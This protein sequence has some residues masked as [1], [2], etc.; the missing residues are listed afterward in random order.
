[1]DATTMTDDDTEEARDLHEIRH[2]DDEVRHYSADGHLYAYREGDEHVVISRGNEP[3]TQWTKR[4][5]ATVEQPTPDQK[6]WTLPDN[7]DQRVVSKRD[8]ITYGLFYVPESDVWVRASIPTNDQLIDAWYQVTAVGDLTIEPIGELG[9]RT[10]VRQLADD[11]EKE[12]DGHRVEEYAKAIREIARNWNVV[13]DDLQAATE[14]VRDEG[15]HET[16]HG[17]PINVD[18]DWQIEFQDRVFRPEGAIKHAVEFPEDDI[19]PSAIFDILREAGLLPS[20][21][22]FELT[23]DDSH[24]D[25]E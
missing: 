14:W 18:R 6:L 23:L 10:E 5:P 24:L 3:Q 11:Y 12:D 8:N 1:M 22:K 21:Y 15:L 16:Q 13:E 2:T 25:V 7:W 19:S 20:Y 4:V 17:Q 9:S